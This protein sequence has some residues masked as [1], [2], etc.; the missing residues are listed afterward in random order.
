MECLYPR[1]RVCWKVVREDGSRKTAC[2]SADTFF[3]RSVFLLLS[4]ALWS[5]EGMGFG[6]MNASSSYWNGM[7]RRPL[8]GNYPISPLF[9]TSA[10]I[11]HLGQ[12]QERRSVESI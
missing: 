8:G 2:G 12:Q 11:L 1:E 9:K 4:A 6:D 7:T 10:L 5:W 3:L